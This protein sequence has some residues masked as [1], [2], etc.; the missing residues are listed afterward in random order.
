MTLPLLSAFWRRLL[1]WYNINQLQAKALVVDPALNRIRDYSFRLSVFD[2]LKNPAE[3]IDFLTRVSG[4]VLVGYASALKELALLTEKRGVA[5][6][7][8]KIISFAETLTA[9]DRNFIEKI[10]GGTVYNFYGAAEFGIIAQECRERDGF[11]I[12]EEGLI[13]EI[14]N[15][16][17]RD[18]WGSILVTSLTNEAMPLI[19]Y[20]IGDA[21]KFEHEPCRCG[22][23]LR[24]IKVAGRN[25]VIFQ[26]Y[27]RKIHEFEFNNVL[28]GFSNVIHCFQV[29]PQDEQSLMIR[30]VAPGLTRGQE[31]EIVERLQKCIDDSVEYSIKRVASI[32]RSL[33]GKNVVG[34]VKTEA[35]A[36]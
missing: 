15:D 27:R 9:E 18:G 12:N 24:K 19:R 31:V 22:V 23:T 3:A 17:G 11:H 16:A 30:V 7:F 4:S 20:N 32:E 29:V 6:R 21:G 8:E 28:G 1:S 10:F 33:R 13:V 5:C 34:V 25:S 26:S 35:P 36:G 2:I 14:D